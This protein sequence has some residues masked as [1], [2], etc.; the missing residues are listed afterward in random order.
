[1]GQLLNTKPGKVIQTVDVLFDF[2]TQRGKVVRRGRCLKRFIAERIALRNCFIP[3]ARGTCLISAFFIFISSPLTGLG[4][5]RLKL[6]SWGFWISP[7]T[8][9][10]SKGKSPHFDQPDLMFLGVIAIA[11]A[12]LYRRVKCCFPTMLA[13]PRYNCST[14]LRY[15][16]FSGLKTATSQG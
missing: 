12:R 3:R 4:D 2:T 10:G 16:A 6:P 7:R 14:C 13:P 9:S 8:R 5:V 11:R 1:M 15:A